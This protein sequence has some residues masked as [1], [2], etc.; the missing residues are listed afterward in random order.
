[1]APPKIE[2]TESRGTRCWDSGSDVAS[3]CPV[4]TLSHMAHLCISHA[5][6]HAPHCIASILT[7]PAPSP[8]LQSQMQDENLPSSSKIS[9][10]ALLDLSSSTMGGGQ[11]KEERSVTT[12]TRRLDLPAETSSFAARPLL[13]W[14]FQS[15]KK[16]LQ[17]I[18]SRTSSKHPCN[19]KRQWCAGYFYAALAHLH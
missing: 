1:M 4:T 8:V 18:F 11:S 6:P 2:R 13:L 9:I 19:S 3:L 5:S 15:R 10:R 14:A 17:A 16:Q 12:A 7:H